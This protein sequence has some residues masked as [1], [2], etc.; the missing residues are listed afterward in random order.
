MTEQQLQAKIDE[1]NEKKKVGGFRPGSGRK[2]KMEEDQIIEKLHPMATTAFAKLHEKI[3]EGDMKA[4]QL[5]CAYYI[6]LPTQ[7]IESKIEGNLNQIAIEIIKPNILLQDNRKV[8]IEDKD[9][10]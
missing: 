7:K 10:M 3:K 9:N 2:K 1:R 4:I 6:G 8:Q 5:F